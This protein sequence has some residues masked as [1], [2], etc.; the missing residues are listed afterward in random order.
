VY[1]QICK[2]LCLPIQ[3][4]N[5]ENALRTWRGEVEWLFQNHEWLL[6]FT[7]VKI[8]EVYGAIQ[9]GQSSRVT[10]EISFLFQNTTSTRSTLN[11]AVKDTLSRQQQ[12]QKCSQMESVGRF[13]TSLF[14]ST[15]VDVST[16]ALPKR[17]H[18]QSESGAFVHIGTEYNQNQLIRLILKIFQGVPPPYSILS[19]RFSTNEEDIKLFMERTRAF[20]GH[21]LILN[22]NQLSYRLQEITSRCSLKN[23]G[24]HSCYQD[25][26]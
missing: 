13:L 16:I 5:A 21:Y 24:D 25:I 26:L 23:M 6:F 22:V 14:A 17:I 4:D 12:L 9:T 3:A 10:Q 8:L 2:Y 7:P 1:T 20:P 15:M 18:Q 19:C 11:K